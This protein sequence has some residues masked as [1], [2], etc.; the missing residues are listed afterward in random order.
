MDKLYN[1]I[2]DTKLKTYQK[3]Y[4]MKQYEN[5]VVLNIQLVQNGT[6]LDLTGCTVRL[7]YQ[8]KNEVLLQMA[9]IIDEKQGKVRVTVLTK[10][11]DTIGDTPVDI[12]IFDEHQKK[13]TSATF[14][15]VVQESIYSNDKIDEE[16]LDLIQDIYS[17]EKERQEAEIQREE[18]E[19]KREENDKIRDD[20]IAKMEK[21]CQ[22]CKEEVNTQIHKFD[23]Q[24][25]ERKANEIERIN[26]ENARKTDEQQRVKQENA[27]EENEKVRVT[28]ETKRVESMDTIEK[29]WEE[30]KKDL[31]SQGGTG[32]M[33]KAIYD[34]NNDG[35]V[36]NS[37][38][39][40]DVPASM[41]IQKQNKTT[42]QDI[43]VNELMS[44]GDT[45]ILSLS[46][47]K[48]TDEL[49]LKPLNDNF[50]KIDEAINKAGY[51]VLYNLYNVSLDEITTSGT[52]IV[53]NL[54]NAPDTP[55]V[56]HRLY[57]VKCYVTNLILNEKMYEI[58]SFGTGKRYSYD[59]RNNTYCDIPCTSSLQPTE[60]YIDSVN[61]NDDNIGYKEHPVKTWECAY[62]RIPKILT[63][64]ITI[65]FL[66]DMES[67][68]KL[69]NISN[70]RDERGM[71][72]TFLQ[73]QGNNHELN[74]FEI[75]NC[76]VGGTS[77]G[78]L[79]EQGNVKSDITIVDSSPLL[80]NHCE[81]K[82]IY[83]DYSIVRTQHNKVGQYE[84]VNNSYICVMAH[85]DMDILNGYGCVASY[86]SHIFVTGTHPQGSTGEKSETYGGKVEYES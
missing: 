72:P 4:G 5:N 34:T 26:N 3:V 38:K 77:Y 57:L 27:R 55:Y 18:N 32:D 41:Y 35:V 70:S 48:V 59:N 45:P 12:S 19:K 79:I 40:G 62:S 54:K 71:T 2:V 80:I 23:T 30:I 61:G 75:S 63:K 33:M 6:P 17:K 73:F 39:L 58:Y 86:G 28:S 10:V 42:W 65:Y 24:E 36:D 1:L 37:E 16:E 7:N 66:S 47:P 25:E 52:Y 76:H 78:I 60:I 81:I 85:T 49:L 15:L 21:D 9:N 74:A 69:S 50:T 67:P 84:A 51:G 53:Q 64:P 22:E 56:N 11:L 20:K 31:G 46:R 14:V 13:I 44:T 8:N 29:E 82:H 43:N 83:C 68:I